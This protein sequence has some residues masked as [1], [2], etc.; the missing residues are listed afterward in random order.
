MS[1]VVSNGFPLKT[2]LLNQ[3]MRNLPGLKPRLRFLARGA[4]NARA[5][6]AHVIPRSSAFF[7]GPQKR[8]NA[9]SCAQLQTALPE[10]LT[11]IL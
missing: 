1:S 3:R 6:R 5:K 4:T 10:V 9:K 8:I 7:R 2:Q 11:A